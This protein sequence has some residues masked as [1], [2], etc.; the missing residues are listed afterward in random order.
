MPDLLVRLPGG[1]GVSREVLPPGGVERVEVEEGFVHD[2][3]APWE[4]CP[5][6]RRCSA[7]GVEW[8]VGAPE[9][10]PWIGGTV[11]GEMRRLRRRVRALLRAVRDELREGLPW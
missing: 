8:G 3:H 2:P 10:R 9:E 4:P 7:P 5:L 6:G 11:S 1:R